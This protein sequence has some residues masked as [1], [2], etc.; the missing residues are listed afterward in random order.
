VRCVVQ[1]LRVTGKN[2]CRANQIESGPSRIRRVGRTP[3]PRLT[4]T[5]VRSPAAHRRTRHLS[6]VCR[7]CQDTLSGDNS[8]AARK[9]HRKPS[10]PQRLVRP[11]PPDAKPY[12]DWLYGQ[13][14]KSV[15]H[16]YSQQV[17]RLSTDLSFV[18]NFRQGVQSRSNNESRR[19]AC[20]QQVRSK[21]PA[22][23]TPGDVATTRVVPSKH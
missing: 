2:G 22:A 21:R 15:V 12:Q 9:T 7:A 16:S 23:G 6:D 5:S 14:T 3:A 19:D 18:D 10:C 13:H 4:R 17:H 1:V 8:P 11:G 20:S